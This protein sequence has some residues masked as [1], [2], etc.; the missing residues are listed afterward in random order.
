[1]IAYSRNETVI[2][3]YIN[4][5]ILVET[6][7]ERQLT[8]FC[9]YDILNISNCKSLQPNMSQIFL[10]DGN[11]TEIKQL[12]YFT[13]NILLESSTNI[14]D[15]VN[16]VFFYSVG[17]GETAFFVKIPNS[18]VDFIR[19]SGEIIANENPIYFCYEFSLGEH[20][21]TIGEKI[22]NTDKIFYFSNGV[23]KSVE[24]DEN[25]F[26]NIEKLTFAISSVCYNSKAKENIFLQKGKIPQK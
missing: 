8:T 4:S 7:R 20:S 15:L 26:S 14:S 16:G 1:M 5:K 12:K 21:F 10:Q 23:I 9:S 11:N 6:L 2:E 19:I 24:T 17:F 25:I 13:G 3:P 18:G 22:Y